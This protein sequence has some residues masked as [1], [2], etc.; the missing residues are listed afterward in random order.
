MSMYMS[1]KKKGLIFEGV[2][3]ILV[4]IWGGGGGVSKTSRRS[5]GGSQQIWRFLGGVKNISI[6]IRGVGD[7]GQRDS[8]LE[9]HHP[10]DVQIP[11]LRTLK[12]SN[13]A[14]GM[15]GHKT[16]RSG[17]YQDHKSLKS[18]NGNYIEEGIDAVSYIFPFI[19]YGYYS[20][21]LIFLCGNICLFH[22]KCF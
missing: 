20:D 22:I 2:K 19:L 3:V 9:Q 18:C 6:K 11:S 5:G 13:L 17:E 4:I 12:L 10:K 8:S 21:I 16:L 15:Q 1:S 14:K 7:F